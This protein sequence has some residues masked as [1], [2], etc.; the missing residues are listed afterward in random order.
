MPGPE[1]KGGGS[2]GNRVLKAKDMADKMRYPRS[3]WWE[4]ASWEE[5][6]QSARV[7][8]STLGLTVEELREEIFERNMGEQKRKKRK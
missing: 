3:K 6:C 1:L 8:Q 5:Y 2:R 4:C 7:P